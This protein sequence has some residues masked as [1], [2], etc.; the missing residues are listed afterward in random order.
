MIGTQ[1][2]F[3]ALYT[4]HVINKVGVGDKEMNKMWLLASKN[5]QSRREGIL[6]KCKLSTMTET[7][8]KTCIWRRGQWL[9]LRR[10][11]LPA[12]L[13]RRWFSIWWGEDHLTPRDQQEW[14]VGAWSTCADHGP[15]NSEDKRVESVWEQLN[16]RLPYL[17]EWIKALV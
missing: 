7:N 5:E 13:W 3:Y 16:I 15:G 17:Q 4:Q 1:N 8:S 6:T 11:E 14:D 10:A 9:C 12:E 2:I